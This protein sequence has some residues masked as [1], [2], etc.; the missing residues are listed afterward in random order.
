MRDHVKNISV[1]LVIA[2]LLLSVGI[3]F[4]QRVHVDEETWSLDVAPESFGWWGVCWT[5]KGWGGGYT[6]YAGDKMELI[7]PKKYY[8]IFDEIFFKVSIYGVVKKP[9]GYDSILYKEIVRTVRY[10]MDHSPYRIVFNKTRYEL[11][12]VETYVK[13]NGSEWKD[14]LCTFKVRL[15]YHTK[16]D[17]QLGLTLIFSSIPFFAI[18]LISLIFQCKMQA[19]NL[20]CRCFKLIKS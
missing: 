4:R 9:Y 18:F 6:L 1:F 11:Y 15:I 17:K 19:E 8:P 12:H 2:I 3:Y 14:Q 13:Y 20:K 16:Q 7:F 5:Q 10:L